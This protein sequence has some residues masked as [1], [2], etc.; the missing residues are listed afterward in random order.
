MTSLKITF[1]DETYRIHH[2]FKLLYELQTTKLYASNYSSSAKQKVMTSDLFYSIKLANT[3]RALS[4][5]DR[6]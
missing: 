3:E 1:D 4:Y 5:F 2:R 6:M